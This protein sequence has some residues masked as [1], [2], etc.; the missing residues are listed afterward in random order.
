MVR[1]AG[2]WRL[3]FVVLA[4]VG[5]SLA[6]AE[7]AAEPAL[8]SA[9]VLA[10]AGAPR[11][12]EVDA[13]RLKAALDAARRRD[14]YATRQLQAGLVDPVARKLVEWAL[15]DVMG[16][17]LPEAELRASARRVDDWP[18][19]DARR[20]ALERAQLGGPIPYTAL[21]RE[22][23][24]QAFFRTRRL[25]MNEAL[26]R[27]EA[28]AA[29]AAI[30]QH[31]QSPGTVEYA[32]GEA[33][34]GWLAL[35]KLRNPTLAEQH[36]ARL[37]AAVKSPVSKARAAYWRGRAA[38]AAGDAARAQRFY[39]QGAAHPSTFYGQL[40]AQSAGQR[41]IVLAPDPAPSASD[42]SSFERAELT[43]VIRLLA[44]ASERG[45]L[46][47]FALHYGGVTQTRPELALLV[48]ELRA[49]GE[50][51]LSLLAYRRGAQQGLILFERGY[52][53]VRSP[54]VPGGAES[55]LVLAITRQESQFDPRV[56][57]AADARGMMQ[58]LPST[59]RLV[60]RDIGTN[61]SES[62][63]WDAEANMRLGSRYLG[64]LTEEFRGSYVL[65]AAGYNAGPR[66][67]PGW[68]AICG[69]PRS[70]AVDPV[71]FIECIPFGETR[72]YVMNVMANYQVY[73]ARL[74]GGRSPLIAE[75]SLRVVRRPS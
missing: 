47:V 62:L 50:Q 41:E 51:E 74:N 52:P 7:V 33:F 10:A 17:Q 30:A 38:Q 42:R 63:L 69:D 59:G 57:S 28:R 46:R 65:A 9:T 14:V 1:T 48:D 3:F 21:D 5:V 16:D 4:A 12:V 20:R 70:P 45:L 55:A 72:N 26:R 8:G 34:A 49:L 18:R 27:G 67:L 6:S 36:F 35:N 23:N 15:I 40:A 44:A 75:T 29:Y 53:M 73:R 13:S 54:V 25:Q 19:A 11:G 24:L 68:I 60:A 22:G 58:I 56:R 2:D 64:Q 61:W 71:D 32:E 31:G 66:R 39:E 43:R 37:D